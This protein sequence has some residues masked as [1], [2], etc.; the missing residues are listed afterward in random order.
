MMNHSDEFKEEA[1][2]IALTS[3]SLVECRVLAMTCR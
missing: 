3:G 2:R 1:M